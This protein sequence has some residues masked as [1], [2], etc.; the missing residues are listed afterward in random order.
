MGS[1]HLQ[2]QSPVLVFD[3][4]ETLI[5]IKALRPHFERLFAD[6]GL[7]REWF[8]QMLLYSQ[9][10]TQTGTYADFGTIARC[11]LEM[12]ATI[13]QKPITADDIATVIRSIRSLPVHPE[14]PGALQRLRNAGFRLVTL[15]NSTKEVVEAQI[16]EAGLSQV[17]ERTFSVDAIRRFK[18]AAE[19]YNYVATQLQVES[20]DL[21]M[22]AAHPWDL[23][24]A[25]AAGCQIAFV[26]RPGTA[27]FPLT[28]LPAITG[29][30]LQEVATQ[31]LT[32][33]PPPSPPFAGS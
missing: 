2:P 7:V 11:A 15:T 27:W 26:Q 18:P 25:R 16:R 20:F 12:V 21:V 6:A 23:M 30:T 4:N 24:G 10:V 9:T 3:V 29:P 19:T 17:F 22:I 5:D 1:Q 28:P 31:I 33:V 14:V 32:R 13:Q 8:S